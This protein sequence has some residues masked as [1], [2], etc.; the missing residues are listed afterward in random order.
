METKK[1]AFKMDTSK[2]KMN[3]TLREFNVVQEKCGKDKG[4]VMVIDNAPCHSRMESLLE[5]DDLKHHI[6]LLLSP[7]SPMLNP[8]ETVWSQNK[9]VVKEILEKYEIMMNPR[10][11]KT[12]MGHRADFWRMK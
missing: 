2:E 10:R 3:A 12:I 6:L 9:S 11:G 8:M 7:Y 1:G 4:V 5:N